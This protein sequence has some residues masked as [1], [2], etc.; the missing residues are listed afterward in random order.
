MKLWVDDVRPAPEGYVWCK[1]VSEAISRILD[2]EIRI[3]MLKYSWILAEEDI[4]EL[5]IELIDL[6]CGYANDGGD[7][8]R[9]LGWLEE[10]ERNYPIRIHSISTQS[11]LEI[12]AHYSVE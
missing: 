4:K 3:S 12:C 5:S 2:S 1:S 6:Y 9:L 10:T 11:E 8:I 7:Y